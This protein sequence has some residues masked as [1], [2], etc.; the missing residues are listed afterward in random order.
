MTHLWLRAEQ[1][2]NEDRT[3]LTPQGA[4][5]LIARGLTVTV[6]D[7]RTRILPIDAYRPAG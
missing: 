3:G 1:R 7:S 5:A 6:E 2:A 4:A